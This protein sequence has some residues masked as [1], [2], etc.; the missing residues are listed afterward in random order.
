MYGTVTKYDFRDALIA[1]RD[2]M[3]L[4][5]Y[6]FGHYISWWDIMIGGCFL[7]IFIKILIQIVKGKD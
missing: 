6:V 7:T 3:M 5:F 2:I 4:E 1:S